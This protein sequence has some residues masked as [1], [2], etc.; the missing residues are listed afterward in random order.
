MLE[1]AKRDTIPRAMSKEVS[2]WITATAEPSAA[3]AVQQLA[4]LEPSA[5]NEDG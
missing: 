4:D 3:S 1:L 5:T 2:R